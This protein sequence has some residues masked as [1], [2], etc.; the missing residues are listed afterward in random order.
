MEIVRSNSKGFAVSKV[1]DAREHKVIMQVSKVHADEQRTIVSQIN[2]LLKSLPAARIE[3]VFQG[4]GLP[5]IVAGE[6]KVAAE[7]ETLIKGG[8]IFAA[9]E[10][11]M[12][13]KGICEADLLP[14]IISVPSAL[15]ELILK[16]E[17][18]W[19]YVKA[20]V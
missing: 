10:N 3:V 2:N 6:T 4:Q 11:A 18:G 5:L 17:K 13:K 14:G 15:A 20:G 1:M 7:V 12:D 16:Q 8:V 9:C 19:I